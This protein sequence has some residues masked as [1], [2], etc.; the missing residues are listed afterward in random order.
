[1]NLP[2]NTIIW[3]A[4]VATTTI[5][6]VLASLFNS[7]TLSV[8]C[9]MTA[10]TAFVVLAIGSG[11]LQSL[12]GRTVLVALLL[13]WLGDLLLAGQTTNSF[14]FGLISFLF[15]HVAYFVAFTNRGIR[16]RIAAKKMG[17]NRCGP[18]LVAAMGGGTIV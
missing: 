18:I 3:L 11:A 6:M 4:V 14:V 15:A 7:N 13:S 12:Y 17:R 2:L 9:K 16:W 10:S 5:A 1:M 8:V